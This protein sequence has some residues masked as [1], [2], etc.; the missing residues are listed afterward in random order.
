MLEE[1]GSS[2]VNDLERIRVVSLKEENRGLRAAD[3]CMKAGHYV[4]PEFFV[5]GIH[6]KHDG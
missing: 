3:Q 1:N 4:V 2:I 5:I 6:I